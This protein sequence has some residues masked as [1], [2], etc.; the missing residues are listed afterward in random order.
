MIPHGLNPSSASP[1]C[2]GGGANEANGPAGHH[3]RTDLTLADGLRPSLASG[4]LATG[5]VRA[6]SSNPGSI[7]VL[8]SR[9]LEP[10]PEQEPCGVL[11]RD[12][13]CV[14]D[15]VPVLLLGGAED[16]EP[17]AGGAA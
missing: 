3:G 7:S 9:A 17:Y 1:G 8:R 11:G 10:S 13:A 5:L 12:L 16:R 15:A 14:L 6:P 4:L 2:R